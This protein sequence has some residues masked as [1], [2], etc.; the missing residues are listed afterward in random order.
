M[1]KLL[2]KV[3]GLSAD[4]VR[5]DVPDIIRI[6]GW[7]S[8]DLIPAP[9]RKK[10]KITI[11][12]FT[13]TAENEEAIQSA[14]SAKEEAYAPLIA[15]I[16]R[17]GFPRPELA[18]L[19]GGVRGWQ[20]TRNDAVFKSI[21]LSPEACRR[22]RR[23]WTFTAWKHLHLLIRWRRTLEFQEPACARSGL[24]KWIKFKADAVIRK[25]KSSR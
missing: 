12:E 9:D 25:R 4:A 5:R 3:L 16:M 19:I 15:V 13:F 7:D 23:S 14:V 10:C 11:V 24:V 8:C 18:I 2:R 1:R 22:I 17:L 6:D 20:P 21:C